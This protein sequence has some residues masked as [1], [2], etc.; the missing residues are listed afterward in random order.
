[1]FPVPCHSICD[2]FFLLL[3]NAPAS[4]TSEHLEVRGELPLAFEFCLDV[5]AAHLQLY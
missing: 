5:T 1:M 2:L 4:V 3:Q